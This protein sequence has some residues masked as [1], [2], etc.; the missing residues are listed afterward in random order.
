MASGCPCIVANTG[1]LAEVVPNDD[2]ALRFRSRDPRSLARMM[3]KVLT[4]A[5]LRERLVAQASEHILRF[6]WVDVARQTRGVYADLVS[7]D[8]AAI[9][10]R[11]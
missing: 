3:E 1:G 2:V 4:D 11:P 8:P 5:A 9:V 10:S 7:V 6:D